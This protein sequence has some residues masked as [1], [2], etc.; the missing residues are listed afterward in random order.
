[1]NTVAESSH[2]C[3][4]EKQIISDF[5]KNH[6]VTYLLRE[7]GAYKHR[8]IPI[9]AIIQFVFTVLFTGKSLFRTCTQDPEDHVKRDTVYRFLQLPTIDWMRFL[10]SLSKQVIDRIIPLTGESRRC[11]FIIDDSF[12]DRSRSRKTELLTKVYDHARHMYGYGYRLLTL[13]WSDGNSFIPV[14]FCLMSSQNTAKQVVSEK[15]VTHTT[16]AYRRELAQ[17]SAPDT[18]M[19]LLKQAKDAGIRASHLL[20]DSWFAFP[21]LILK[22]SALGYHTLAMVKKSKKIYYEFEGKRQSVKDIFKS[23]KK[24]RGRSRYLLSVSVIISNKDGGSIPARLVFVR[25]RSNRN[26]YLVLLC[27]D[28]SMDEDDIIQT[29][30]KRWAIEVFFKVAKSYLKIVKG[31]SSRSYDA[32]TAHTAITCAQ[33]IML[34]ELQRLHQDTRSIGDLFFDTFDE[35]QDISYQESLVLILS[36]I[37]HA[38]TE[39]LSLS[40]DEQKKLV[41]AFISTVPSILAKRLECVT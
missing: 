29:Y 27:T 31:C 32:I 14:N 34:A 16:A 39:A 38:V 13:G 20:F 8:G 11:V 2:F 24:R 3:D 5:L 12:Y 26:D 28:M 4:N 7:S 41:E 35:L 25:N 9:A 15:R 21:A 40:S 22:I 10:T 17:Q 33:Y 6:K 18:A 19:A 23:C 36:A 1:M 37:F 30:G